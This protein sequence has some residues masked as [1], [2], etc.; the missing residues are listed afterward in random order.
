MTALVTGRDA[1]TEA[2]RRQSDW[3]GV[4]R[5]AA[6]L[7]ALLLAWPAHA[8]SYTE[9][10][11][12]ALQVRQPAQ[13][14]LIGIA[15]AGSRLVAVG[16]HG[17][18]IYSDDNGESWRQAQVPVSVTIT[19]VG[20][21]SPQIGWAG[22]AFGVVLQTSDGGANWKTSLNGPQVNQLMVAAANARAGAS[23]NDPLAAR[24]LRRA[25][26]LAAAGPD[27]PFI[28]VLAQS[29][30]NAM[31]FGGYRLCVRTSDGG[32]H[33]ADCSMDIADSFSH[34]LYDVEQAGP[35]IYLAGESGVVFRSDNQG[36]SFVALTPPSQT[37]IFGILCTPKGT[38]LAY[39]VAGGL[40]RSVDQGQTWM[41]EVS[42]AQSDV[43]GGIVLNSGAVAIASISGGIYIS[44]D[45][46]VT[47]QPC[48]FNA[49]MALFGMAQA[50]NGNLAL[51][52]SAGARILPAAMVD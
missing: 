2:P 27:K 39:G 48:A 47:F 6:F 33:W 37:T 36:A 19:C 24:A 31:I 11:Q 29:P 17:V 12:H 42:P 16:E 40:Y 52:G 7:L 50:P 15:R 43:T 25:N 34:N 10:A 41:P 38:L 49:G 21:A 3:R 22:G 26:I 23:P 9:L 4:L 14:L 5:K 35:A 18:I 44:H 1:L 13:A 8:A 32:A 20:F 28:T 30:R 51:I 46:G 45:D